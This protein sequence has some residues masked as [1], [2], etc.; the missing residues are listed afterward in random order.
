MAG[1]H[2]GRPS[3]DASLERRAPVRDGMGTLLLRYQSS[4]LPTSP[5]RS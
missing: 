3:T 2:I 5:A 1:C 4:A